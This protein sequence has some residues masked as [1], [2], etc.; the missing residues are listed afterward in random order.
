MNSTAFNC[1]LFWTLFIHLYHIDLC[2]ENL[3]IRWFCIYLRFICIKLT[4]TWLKLLLWI[5]LFTWMLRKAITEDFLK[6]VAYILGK[7]RWSRRFKAFKKQR[8]IGF[9]Y[10]CFYEVPLCDGTC[11]RNTLVINSRVLLSF[12]DAIY[13]SSFATFS[14][15]FLSP[16]LLKKIFSFP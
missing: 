5:Q 11:Y 2:K 10:L 13:F 7:I 14:E 3:C 16:L 15:I 9:G 8:I 6:G 12:P 1:Q 4:C